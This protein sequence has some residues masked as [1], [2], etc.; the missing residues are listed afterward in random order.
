MTAVVLFTRDL[1]VADHPALAEA[2]TEH[3]HVVPLF[4]LDAGLLG[5]SPNRDRF[6]MQSLQDLDGSLVR[7]GA[8][9][10]V[11]RGD[12][13]TEA[14][15]TARQAGAAEVFVTGDVSAFARRRLTALE[16]A[17]TAVGARLRVRP[18]GEVVEPGAVLPAGKPAY[19]VFTPYHRAWLQAADTEL[20]PT[21][22]AL[23]LPPGTEVGLIPD[24]MDVL[25]PDSPD[26]PRGG[27]RTGRRRLHSFLGTELAAYGERRDRVDLE[28]TARLSPYLRFGCVSPRELFARA[29]DLPG[30]EPFLRQLAWRDFF[31]QQEAV[32]GNAGPARPLPSSLADLFDAWCA[33]RTGVPM[34]DA[35]MR[36]LMREGWMHNRA[37]LVTSSFLHRRLR[38]PWQE[39]A[40]HFERWLVDGDRASDAG[41]WRWSADTTDPRRALPLNAVR[42]ARRCDPSGAYIRRYVPELA[43][44]EAPLVFEPWRRPSLLRD[45][46]Y[47]APIVDLETR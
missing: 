6:L 26:L 13:V 2:A 24:G 15:R 17:T 14:A 10:I 23:R 21:P 5:R 25:Q 39:G 43:G 30:A 41:N 45:T 44:V 32:D 20:A 4:V 28:G 37:R 7:L 3:E 36:Q 1:R 33:G 38:I 8:R 18:G 12:V 22:R 40:R 29:R 46:G 16:T 19:R 11:R 9:L 35:G 27:E 31:R 34:V 42:Q 47:P